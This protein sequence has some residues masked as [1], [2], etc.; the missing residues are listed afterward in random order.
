MDEVAALEQLK[1]LH[2]RK[3]QQIDH[4]HTLTAEFRHW[5]G[6]FTSQLA[7]QREDMQNMRKQ[8]HEDALKQRSEFQE[9]QGELQRQLEDL[10][11]SNLS[12]FP[13][14][15]V[16]REP[17][18]AP[19]PMQQ[20]HRHQQPEPREPQQ[21]QHPPPHP[22]MA[23]EHPPQRSSRRAPEPAPR[24]DEPHADSSLAV[25]LSHELGIPVELLAS[26]GRHGGTGGGDGG[27]GGGAPSRSAA[28]LPDGEPPSRVERSGGGRGGGGERS[29]SRSRDTRSRS[30]DTDTESVGSS[31]YSRSA[32][33]GRGGSVMSGGSSPYSG[34]DYS[35][36]SGSD[37]SGRSGAGNGG[38]SSYSDYSGS[39]SSYSDGGR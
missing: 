15:A 1:S 30:R 8:L 18:A 9:M 13:V 35:D 5:R 10:I 37:V 20:L 22:A 25:K 2:Q 11:T 21:Y 7:A 12:A 17:S 19:P 23:P 24:R 6:D 39:E 32:R 29:R 28:P 38:G 34:S 26:S 31:M 4:V 36:D 27:G 3:T 14:L 16:D 33:S